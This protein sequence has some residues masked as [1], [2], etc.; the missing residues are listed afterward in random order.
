MTNRRATPNLLDPMSEI[1][2]ARKPESPK[3]IKQETP[4]AQKPESNNSVEQADLEG[5]GLKEKATYN[6][7]KDLLID[8]EETWINLRRN[9]RGQRITKTMIVEE[10]IRYAIEDLEKNKSASWLYRKVES[11]KGSKQ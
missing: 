4:K 6:L 1:M 7:S 11:N 8:L 5:E 10:A 3:A 2:G 9:H